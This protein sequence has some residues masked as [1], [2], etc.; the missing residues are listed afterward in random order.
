MI[1]FHYPLSHCQSYPSS[2]SRTDLNLSPFSFPS[3]PFPLIS[4][5]PVVLPKF[6]Y[7][8]RRNITSY[9]KSRALFL[10]YLESTAKQMKKESFLFRYNKEPFLE[11]DIED[12]SP[13]ARPPLSRPRRNR[14]RKYAR[15]VKQGQP[16]QIVSPPLPRNSSGSALNTPRKP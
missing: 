3:S 7:Y 10:Y 5:F 9:L 1:T 8:I 4:H 16:V 2:S 15:E 6:G 12:S 11:T 14:H 13:L